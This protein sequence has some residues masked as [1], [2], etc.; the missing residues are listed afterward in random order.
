L[1]KRRGRAKILANTIV[2]IKDKQPV[3]LV[4]VRDRR[5]KYWLVLLSTDITLS[6]SEIVKL[7]GKRWD[8]EVFFKMEKQHLKLV[9]E[10]QCR[11]FDALIAH[12]TI[13]FMRYMF[14]AYNCRCETDQRTFGDL[15]YACCDE[16]RDISFIE[17]LCRI[18][19]LA[20]HQLQALENFCEKTIQIFFNT[21]ME[22]ALGSVGLARSQLRNTK[23]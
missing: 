13:V 12:T 10:I 15:F 14:V 1:R 8:I 22:T 4:F 7:Y 23:S 19:T 2:T 5:K 3:K 21:L 17:S 18:L 16:L 6:E 11:D 9:K 20:V